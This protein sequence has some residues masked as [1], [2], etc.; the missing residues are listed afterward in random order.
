MKNAPYRELI[1]S[2]MH[3]ALSTRPDIMFTTSFLSQYNSNLGR[4]HWS[5]AKRVL[6]YLNATIHRKLK[7]DPSGFN[8]TVYSDADWAKNKDDSIS[9]SGMASMIGNNLI[10]WKSSKQKSVATSTMEA[11]Y[12]ALAKAAKEMTWL[13][14]LFKELNFLDYVDRSA[15]MYCDNRAAIQF[16]G[17]RVE[18]SN[19]RHINISYHFVRERLEEGLFQLKYVSTTENIA[20]MFTKGLKGV[21]HTRCC[22]KLNLC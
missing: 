17:S 19:T 7:Y 1:G 5:A 20:D 14:M 4:K 2:L 10:N 6:R 22:K 21:A 13:S 8:L 12:M 18:N 3:L 11:E 9:F 15:T 16:A